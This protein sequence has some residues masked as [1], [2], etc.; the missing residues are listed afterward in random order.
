MITEAEYVKM[1]SVIL[2]FME[3]VE[4]Q[5]KEG[6]IDGVCDPTITMDKAEGIMHSAK[7]EGY[8]IWLENFIEPI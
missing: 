6:N 4:W 3:F 1:I 8:S 7:E 2:E 5:K